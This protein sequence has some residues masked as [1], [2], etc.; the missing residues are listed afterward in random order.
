M[1]SS[2]I[3]YTPRL[4]VNTLEN[5]L[6]NLRRWCSSLNL[7]DGTRCCW[8]RRPMAGRYESAV[9]FLRIEPQYHRDKV[10]QYLRTPMVPRDLS[11]L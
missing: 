2:V 7:V 1:V 6:S 8:H 11:S 5:D 9:D 4:C 10:G 3:A